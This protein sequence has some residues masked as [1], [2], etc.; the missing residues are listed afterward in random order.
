MNYKLLYLNIKILQ[1]HIHRK[2]RGKEIVF[3]NHQ[4]I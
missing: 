2:K 1:L 3:R 4:C